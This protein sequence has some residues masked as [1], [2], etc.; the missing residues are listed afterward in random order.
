VVDREALGDGAAYGM[1][2]DDGYFESKY[3]HERGEIRREVRH[4]VAR[5]GATRV[6][7]TPLRQG[8]G[9]DGLGQERQHGLEGAPGVQET[10]HEH[11]GN[12]CRVSLLDVG[13]PYPA[14]KLDDPDDGFVYY[15]SHA[16]TST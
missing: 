6:A 11:D 15:W 9:V 4:S 16:S 13:E 1:P 14:V 5:G 8:E 10:V 2:D 7:V 3:V 12:A